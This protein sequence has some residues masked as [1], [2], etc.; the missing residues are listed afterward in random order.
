MEI[1][2]SSKINKYNIYLVMSISNLF[3]PND[4][5]LECLNLTVAGT[6][7]AESTTIFSLSVDTLDATI[8]NAGGAVIQSLQLATTGGTATPLT[9][10]EEYTVNATLTGIWAADQPCTVK[11]TR[12]GNQCT[13]MLAGNVFA[14]AT[15]SSTIELVLAGGIPTRFCP[16]VDYLSPCL[17]QDDSA[18]VT[19]NGILLIQNAGSMTISNTGGTPFTGA[20]NSGVFTFGVSYLVS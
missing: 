11:I 10:Y 19:T 3:N 12:V 8:L 9:Y 7:T 16:V 18:F 1:Y 17:I 20:G 13:F 4:Y 2:I 15:I 6:L 14:T 5:S